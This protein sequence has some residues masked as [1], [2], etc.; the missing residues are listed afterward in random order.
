MT[1]GRSGVFSAYLV[2]SINKT[3]RHNITEIFLKVALNTITL[4]LT[5]FLVLYYLS[6]LVN[7]NHTC[8]NLITTHL[9]RQHLSVIYTFFL[10]SPLRDIFSTNGLTDNKHIMMLPIK[11]ITCTSVM[12]V[13]THIITSVT[14]TRLAVILVITSLLI[15][16]TAVI[17]HL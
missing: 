4:S 5:P 12:K 13:T 8:F 2:S 3:D 6:L 14:A 10:W 16:I 11:T 17:Q 9:K 1:C 7:I 15:F